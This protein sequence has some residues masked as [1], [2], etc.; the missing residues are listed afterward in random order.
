MVNTKYEWV[1]GELITAEKLNN[2]QD[3]LL[4]YAEEDFNNKFS[5]S[6]KIL[7][8]MRTVPVNKMVSIGYGDIV[9]INGAGVDRISSMGADISLCVL[10]Y[11]KDIHDPNPISADYTKLRSSIDTIRN[12]GG[13]V[14][15]L[16]PHINLDQQLDSLDRTTYDPSD[17]PTFFANWGNLLVEYA[18][19][20]KEKDIPILSIGCETFNLIDNKY[21]SYWQEIVRRIKAVNPDLKITYAMSVFE[22]S[23]PQNQGTINTVVDYIGMNIYPSWTTKLWSS[24]VTY[25]DLI[26]GFYN[27]NGGTNYQNVM[28]Y[29]SDK[30]NKPVLITEIGFM[31][32]PDAINF[33][34]SKTLN[35][36]PNFDVL[37]EIMKAVFTIVKNTPNVIGLAWWGS[38]ST[39]F[40]FFKMNEVTVTEKILTNYY[41]TG[42]ILDV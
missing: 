35:D 28:D 21:L 10:V 1:D 19:I 42:E 4:N 7:P 15:M 32:Q 24:G 34:I 23:Y 8:Y 39:P 33:L 11:V 5:Q 18:N 6:T 22:Y 12:G 37:A 41:K 30:Y 14:G 31:P 13:R 16:K 17:Y 38:S 3:L 2:S 40:T 9:P 26:P 20:A 27:D 25:K 29:F 36:T